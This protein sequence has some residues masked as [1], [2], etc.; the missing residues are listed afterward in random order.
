ML[1]TTVAALL[2]LCG[3]NALP[4]ALAESV[5]VFRAREITFTTTLIVADAPEAMVPTEQLSVPVEPAAGVLHVPWVALSLKNW[6][7]DGRESIAATPDALVGPK[8]LTVMV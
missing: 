1:V 4:L 2:L 3:S 7:V 5:T 8:F 6:T